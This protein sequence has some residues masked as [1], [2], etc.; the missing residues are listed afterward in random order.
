VQ[1]IPAARYIPGQEQTEETPWLMTPSDSARTPEQPLPLAGSSSVTGHLADHV[2]LRNIR[3]D[4]RVTLSIE[5]DIPAEGFSPYL[6]IEGIARVEEG[7]AV[8]LL[9]RITGGQ[10]PKGSSRVF[11]LRN[12]PVPALG[13]SPTEA[14]SG[15]L[16][17]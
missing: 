11:R 1:V 10:F 14:G 13:V 12:S 7:G 8:P 3:R 17:K 6:V 5:S 9:R 15:V 4:P 16:Q 2:K